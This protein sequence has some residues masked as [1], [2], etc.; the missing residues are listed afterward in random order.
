MCQIA[1][2]CHIDGP[3]GIA[4]SAVKDMI[5]V[6]CHRGP[7]EAGIYLDDHVELRHARLSIIDLA[8]CLQPVKNCM[9][10]CGSRT[11]GNQK[12]LVWRGHFECG[13]HGKKPPCDSWL[14]IY[15]V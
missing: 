14:L 6:L 15:D 1:G 9:N 13:R 4:L 11:F 7:D 12:D 8:S 2:I 10:S 3:D 5:G